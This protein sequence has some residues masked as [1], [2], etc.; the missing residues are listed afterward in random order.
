MKKLNLLFL[1]F[2]LLIISSC[3]KDT[4]I[5]KDLQPNDLENTLV[6]NEISG[7]S[8]DEI[9]LREYPSSHAADFFSLDFISSSSESAQAR[10]EVDPFLLKANET[11]YGNTNEEQVELL[12]KS[13]GYPAWDIGQILGIY[14]EQGVESVYVPAFESDK[15]TIKSL[16]RFEFSK[17]ETV[18]VRIYDATLYTLIYKQ[19]PNIDQAI[20]INS[21]FDYFS[22]QQALATERTED[23]GEGNCHWVDLSNGRFCVWVNG[24]NGGYSPCEPECC[25]GIEQDQG[26]E[27]LADW[28]NSE[29][30]PFIPLPDRNN[31][32][33]ITINPVFEIIN[34]SDEQAMI[35]SLMERFGWNATHPNIV[36]LVTYPNYIR[37][38]IQYV[39]PEAQ[40][41][42]FIDFMNAHG[43]TAQLNSD[44]LNTLIN[45]EPQERGILNIGVLDAYLNSHND[46]AVSNFVLHEIL[47]L[48]EE[49]NSELPSAGPSILDGF[50]RALSSDVMTWIQDDEKVNFRAGINNYLINGGPFTEVEER[51][52][53]ATT[54]SGLMFEH[55]LG[56]DSDAISYLLSTDNQTLDEIDNFLEENDDE[57]SRVSSEIYGNL[58]GKDLLNVNTNNTTNLQQLQINKIFDDAFTGTLS[59]HRQLSAESWLKIAQTQHNSADC[60]P[61]C[62]FLENLRKTINEGWNAVLKPFK[63]ALKTVFANLGD[64]MPGV[65]NNQEWKALLTIYGP[66]LTE[67]GID[68]GTDFIPGIGELK[69]FYKCSNA[70]AAEK[71]GDAALEFIGA[72]LGILPVGDFISA[73]GNIVVTGVKI[74]AAYKVI[75][76]VAKVSSGLFNKITTLAGQGWE[77]V[78]NDNLKKLIFRNPD[79]GG[80]VFEM[81]VRNIDG[82]DVPITNIKKA[83]GWSLFRRAE[84]ENLTPVSPG[85]TNGNYFSK[86]VLNQN[87]RRLQVTEPADIANLSQAIRNGDPDGLL[88]EE[89]ADKMFREI[90]PNSTGRIWGNG[91]SHNIPAPGNGLDNL[92]QLPD[93]T[94]VIA[95]CKPLSSSGTISLG[96]PSAGT[97]M[98]NN[99][100]EDAADK[101]IEQTS[102]PSLQNWG[103]TVKNAIENGTPIERV[104][105]AVDK[106]NGDIIIT[107]LNAFN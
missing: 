24:N 52:E 68:I 48:A 18:F 45:L 72:I 54:L 100:I 12:I 10:N 6:L 16:I 55:D 61:D 35:A 87:S 47:R 9:N 38:I 33:G 94:L 79:L 83:N 46:D 71:Y 78:W 41:Q 69:G 75:K 13:I 4:D 86:S 96:T 25:N 29:I 80:D 81:T 8:S 84:I 99:W 1:L 58:K 2:L 59:E 40:V 63:E 43:N 15:K 60:P 3:K 31:E 26:N 92:L 102:N 91:A 77:F 103:N 64:A 82:V 107:R 67:L 34:T 57:Y 44:E 28:F 104:L 101:M 36:F 76:A 106:S 73:T 27:D 5:E 93:G 39:G 20:H 56:F 11:L 70:Y 98:S 105:I 49:N 50:Y 32:G 65:N 21:L 37:T 53:R 90:Y 85:G 88:T 51:R 14:E 62:S 23:C 95:E 22:K 17:E 42:K 19:H 89:L 30:T 74:F 66:M 7:P 97:Q